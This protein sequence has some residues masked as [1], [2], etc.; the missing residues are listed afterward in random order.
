MPDNRRKKLNLNDSNSYQA[1]EPRRCLAG[2]VNVAVSGSTLLITGDTDS[3][4]IIVAP[5]ET[6]NSVTVSGVDTTVNGNS[7]P[8]TVSLRNRNVHFQLGAGD[9]TV[10]A[11]GLVSSETVNFIGGDGN[12]QFNY[13]TGR[14][15]FLHINGG[16]GNDVINIGNI[17]ADK[18]AYMHLEAGNDVVAADTFI[19]GR[20]LKV[21]GGEGDDSFVSNTLSVGKKLKLNLDNGD[22]SAF[23]TGQTDVG[24]KAKVDLGDGND[25]LSF[26]PQNANL[27]L[28]TKKLKVFAGDGDDNVSLSGDLEVRR[29]AK[30]DGG[31]GTDNLDESGQSNRTPRLVSF[32]GET[33]NLD[34]VRD[35]LFARLS[36][37]GIDTSA[38]GDTIDQSVVVS[39]SAGDF[40]F[41]EGDEANNI[42]DAITLTSESDIAI[43]SASVSLSEFDT[44]QDVL[45][46]ENSDEIV[47]ILDPT[48][49]VVTFEAASGETGS[50]ADFQEALRSVTYQNTSVSPTT[51]RREFTFDVLVNGQVF[52]GSRGL[53]VTD[54]NSAPEI[55]L[56]ETTRTA[57]LDQL[58]FILDSFIELSD[59]DDT[60]FESATVSLLDGFVEDQDELS[61]TAQTGITAVFDAT[62]GVLDLS[63]DL[64]QSTLEEFLRNVTFDTS[65]TEA[66]GSSRTIQFSVSDVDD[67]TSVQLALDISAES[68]S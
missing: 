44:D 52:T 12:D 28:R 27:Q 36:G 41:N 21:F 51:E 40:Q 20:N 45:G 54:T 5:S 60:I 9:D 34:T 24:R 17:T 23:F 2:N 32:E 7:E 68:V 4:E 48:T 11:T 14:A 55:T 67:T 31:E 37:L 59:D 8:V 42:D 15:R 58:P 53:L 35:A 10:T 63:G 50:L 65:A 18:S 43:T 26:E 39:P 66:V 64:T 30:L 19:V 22:D 46:F 57:P 33:V 1:L 38:F 62:T 56:S 25:S 6:Q 47:G 13:S 29:K 3:N 49:G 16:D 61:F